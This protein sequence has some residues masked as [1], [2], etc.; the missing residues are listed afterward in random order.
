[1]WRRECD[2]HRERGR[3]S[4]LGDD[5]QAK[6]HLV[7]E[8]V[9]SAQQ[10]WRQKVSSAESWHPAFRAW[11]AWTECLDLAPE[12]EVPT[13]STLPSPS[14]TSLLDIEIAA[15]V[16][17]CCTFAPSAGLS[18]EQTLLAKHNLAAACPQV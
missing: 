18:D 15:K 17:G 6:L 16:A 8:I 4:F 3:L 2:R 14:M 11:V 9:E 12:K 10:R 13:P 5:S 1:M 7:L